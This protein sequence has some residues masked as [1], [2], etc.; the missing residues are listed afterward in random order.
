[1][2]LE[3]PDIGPVLLEGITTSSVLPGDNQ[4]GVMQTRA[5]CTLQTLQIIL[6]AKGES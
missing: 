1:M 2:A 3:N 5:P 4:Q 6:G